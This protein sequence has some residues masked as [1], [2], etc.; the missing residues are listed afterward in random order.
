MRTPAPMP[1][2]LETPAGAGV[3]RPLAG[4][5][6]ALASRSA[7]GS[8][9]TQ[10]VSR[11]PRERAHASSSNRRVE[12]TLMYSS[13]QALSGVGVIVSQVA[14]WR[15]GSPGFD[16][17]ARSRHTHSGW[18]RATAGS[19]RR[20]PRRC[21]R[22]KSRS[23]G[24]RDLWTPARRKAAPGNSRVGAGVVPPRSPFLDSARAGLCCLRLRDRRGF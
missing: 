7:Q 6:T 20:R 13:V 23:V 21:A 8:Q 2:S 15:I 11:R 16:H 19:R 5:G 22:V 3:F 17:A 14:R 12:Q 9:K 10:G 1:S 24:A 4:N 18:R